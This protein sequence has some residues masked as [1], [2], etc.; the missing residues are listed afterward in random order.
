MKVIAISGHAKNGKDTVANII[1]N[2]LEMNGF[3]VQI[4][5]YADLLKFICKR[6]LGWN[7][8]KDEEGRTLLQE[9]GTYGFRWHD[10][11]FWVDFVATVLEVLGDRWD[12]VLIPDTRFPNE[13]DVLKEKGFDVTHLRVVRSDANT[14]LTEEQQKHESETALDDVE[15]D[16]YVL[17]NGTFS[18]LVAAMQEF[19]DHCIILDDRDYNGQ[20]NIKDYVN[21]LLAEAAKDANL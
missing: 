21:S 15:P 1:E 19:T 9:V 2:E 11:N 20:F 18:E 7:G 16:V 6:Y 14:G 13:I 8:K 5:H 12:Y 4:I 17:N 3:R 10:P